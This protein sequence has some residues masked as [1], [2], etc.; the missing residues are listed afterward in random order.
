[1][2]EKPSPVLPVHTFTGLND[3]ILPSFGDFPH[4]I[5]WTGSRLFQRRPC[6][7]VLLWYLKG[8]CLAADGRSAD[9]GSFS[10]ESFHTSRLDRLPLANGPAANTISNVQR[11]A[12]TSGD[13]KYRTGLQATS[14]PP[15]A[16]GRLLK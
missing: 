16:A 1:M 14:H 4:R 3:N 10:G 12:P 8:S 7:L 5:W 9:G 15:P 6:C 2:W 13:E 11:L